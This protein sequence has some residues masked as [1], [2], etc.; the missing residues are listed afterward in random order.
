VLCGCGFAQHRGGNP[1]MAHGTIPSA[2]ISQDNPRKVAR[3]FH[4]LGPHLMAR[5]SHADRGSSSW[6]NR[7]PRLLDLACNRG[8]R[9]RISTARLIAQQAATCRC[10]RYC[11][12]CPPTARVADR[13][14]RGTSA[15]FTARSS[16]RYADPGSAR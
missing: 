7:G 3:R 10:P 15:A 2:L 13:Q 8:R 5:S 9:G 12:S 16:A 14:A 6:A 4:R 1:F 11:K